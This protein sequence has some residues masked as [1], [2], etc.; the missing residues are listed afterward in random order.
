M[1]RDAAGGGGGGGGSGAPCGVE[2]AL[3]RL[4]RPRRGF[5]FGFLAGRFL[6]TPGGRL[7]ASCI[8]NASR[9]ALPMT[10][11]RLLPTM[12]AIASTLVLRAHCSFR[13][14]TFSGVQK[15]R[16]GSFPVR[17]CLFDHGLFSTADKEAR[18]APP[19]RVN[20]MELMSRLILYQK[21]RFDTINFHHGCMVFTCEFC[22]FS[23]RLEPGNFHY[24]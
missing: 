5:A 24:A 1:G 10:A 17:I 2:S 3:V 8:G 14:S 13:I 23:P 21:Q 7:A 19:R 11:L 12:T 9:C 18:C 6:G 15:S 4:F 22:K 16:M 20:P